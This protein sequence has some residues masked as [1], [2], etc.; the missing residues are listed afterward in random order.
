MLAVIG[1]IAVFAAV[2]GGYLL[3]QGNP[4]VLLQP[5][6]LLIVVGAAAGT[7]LV[8]NPAMLIRR[9]FAGTRDAFRAPPH[10]RIALLLHLRMLYEVFSY[11]QR[12]GIVGLEND[13]DT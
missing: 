2:L 5:A 7:V 10:G 1:I 8:A 3:E 13:V 9:M 6:E 11:A 12:A 4:W